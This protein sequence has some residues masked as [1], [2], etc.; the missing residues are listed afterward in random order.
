MFYRA[1]M[2][3]VCFLALQ[4]CEVEEDPYVPVP[5][6]PEGPIYGEAGEEYVT[7]CGPDAFRSLIGQPQEVLATLSLPDGARVIRP[8]LLYTQDYRTERLNVVVG[9]AGI[10]QRVYCG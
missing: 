5:V 9:N 8:G 4:G 1:L 10:I 6:A 3:T 7:D 2:I